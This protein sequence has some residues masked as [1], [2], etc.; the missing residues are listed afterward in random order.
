MTQ[1][2]KSQVAVSA[3]SAI[4]T[5]MFW[6][7]LDSHGSSCQKSKLTVKRWVAYTRIATSWKYGD[8]DGVE[9]REKGPKDAILKWSSCQE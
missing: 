6:D 9:S 4:V 2:F 7:Y 1:L 5:S 3:Y 8:F